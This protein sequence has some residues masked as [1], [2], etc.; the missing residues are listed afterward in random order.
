MKKTSISYGVKLYLYKEENEFFNIKDKISEIIL[1]T[2]YKFYK[3][4]LITIENKYIKFNDSEKVKKRKE[5]LE[6]NEKLIYKFLKSFTSEGILEISKMNEE[7]KSSFLYY[8][9][10]LIDIESEIK[11]DVK[12]LS[13]KE[14]KSYMENLDK[15]FSKSI[16]YFKNE[17]QEDIS[18][19]ELEEYIII[20]I[21]LGNYKN[22]FKF[23]DQNKYLNHSAFFNSL[24]LFSNFI[25]VENM[26]SGE[27]K[28]VQS[29][30]RVSGVSEI[31]AYVGANHKSLK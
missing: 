19:E 24:I 11:S 10:Q 4:E 29:T 27:E 12:L 25:D 13:K 17:Q 16:Q 15:I 5:K 2:I 7:M 14:K 20:N 22:I 9:E 23:I 21:L 6:E 8:R 31:E 26:M 28:K 18:I 30:L 3:E 1:A